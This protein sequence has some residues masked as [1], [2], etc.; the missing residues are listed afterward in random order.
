MNSVP[1]M[2]PALIE[3]TAPNVFNPWR[4]IDP[5][6]RHQDQ[7]APGA[8]TGRLLLHFNRQPLLLLIG[9]A[10]GYRGCHFS[11]VPFTSEALLLDGIPR[12][13]C[14]Q[15]I[16]TRP[17]PCAEAS[18]TIVWGAL[19]ELAIAEHVVMW[20]ACPWH[21]YQPCRPDTNRTPT[22]DELRAGEP[23]LRAI[24]R[25]F[26]G[27]PLAAAGRQAEWLLRQMNVKPA[28]VLRHPS[29]G[30][31]REFRAGLEQLIKT[32]PESRKGDVC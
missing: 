13:I 14:D 30:G 31:A 24:V 32:R 20:N 12:V 26:D 28:A 2:F 29:R 18:A 7:R 10:P 19:R 11:G 1:D 23:I 16:T 25:H 4:D 9:E 5:L 22:G 6:D 27:V 17:T 3:F 15:R 8:R 21:P